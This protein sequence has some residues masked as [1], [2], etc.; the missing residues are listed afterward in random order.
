LE[1]AA[2]LEDA[3]GPE[4]IVETLDRAEAAAH[5]AAFVARQIRRAGPAGE[6]KTRAE[7]AKVRIDLLRARLVKA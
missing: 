2:E 7:T 1:R 5:E 3:P 6:L 4:V